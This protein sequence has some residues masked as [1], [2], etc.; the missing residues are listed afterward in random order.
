MR[1]FSQGTKKCLVIMLSIFMTTSYA[2]SAVI[3]DEAIDGDLPGDRLLAK[4]ISLPPIVDSSVFKV[5]S[6]FGTVGSITDPADTWEIE[7][8]F[9]HR[10]RDIKIGADL[11]EGAEPLRFRTFNVVDRSLATGYDIDS[12]S[13]LSLRKSLLI[14]PLEGGFP[15]ERFTP[16]NFGEGRH[17][18]EF[19]SADDPPYVV[20]IEL[21]LVPE[22]GT[23]GMLL[24]GGLMFMPHRAR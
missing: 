4:V 19:K 17:G 11:V 2:A 6:V 23:I 18:M 20:D 21:E 15:G 3:Y 22:P 14:I 1:Q 9:G 5:W 8:P 16:S 10:I 13:D 7:V 24:L 12:P